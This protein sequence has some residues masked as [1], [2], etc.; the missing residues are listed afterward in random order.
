VK[1][2]FDLGVRFFSLRG[3]VLLYERAGALGREEEKEERGTR[4]PEEE[5]AREEGKGKLEDNDL[6][7]REARKSP[8]DRSIV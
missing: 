7:R 8:T 2:D 4:V 5:D 6:Q 1:D 3:R